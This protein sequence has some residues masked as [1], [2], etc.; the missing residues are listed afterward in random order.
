VRKCDE[1]FFGWVL[2]Q[3]GV[4]RLKIAKSRGVLTHSG[5]EIARIAVFEND[6][7]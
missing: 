3:A 5:L 1:M 2:I 4:K 6:F 7:A